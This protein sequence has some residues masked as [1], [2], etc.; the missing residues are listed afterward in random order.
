MEICSLKDFSKKFNAELFLY[1]F[2]KLSNISPFKN[3]VETSGFVIYK[4]R[5]YLFRIEVYSFQGIHIQ[6][7]VYTIFKGNTSPATTFSN[8]DESEYIAEKEYEK[9]LLPFIIETI[10]K[11]YPL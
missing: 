3:L 2:T 8:F 9:Y 1:H 11:N 4:E 7:D 10:D 5:L 6:I